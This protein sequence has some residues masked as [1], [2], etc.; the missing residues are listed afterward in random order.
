MKVRC[1]TNSRWGFKDLRYQCVNGQ[2]IEIDDSL[3]DQAIASG[4]FEVVEK[5][6]E[7]K[8]KK[9]VKEDDK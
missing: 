3:R 8:P 6:K 2:E 7:S 1:L 4:M 5:P 9:E